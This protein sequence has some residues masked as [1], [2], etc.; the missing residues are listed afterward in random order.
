[1]KFFSDFSRKELFE[2]YSTNIFGLS[3]FGNGKDAHRTWEMLFFGMIPIGT[4]N[5]LILIFYLICFIFSFMLS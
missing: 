3:P 2:E 5:F 1:M 4:L